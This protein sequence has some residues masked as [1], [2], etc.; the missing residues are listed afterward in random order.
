[1][2]FCSGCGTQ[3]ADGS[4]LCPACSAKAGASAPAAGG[5]MS[6]NVAGMLA[7]VTIIPAIVFLVVA[8]YNKS[9]FVRFHAFQNIFFCI[10][11][12]VLW[13]ALSFVGMIPVLGWA[14]LLIW[15]LLGLGGL[16]LWIIL[17]LKANQGQMWKLP[18]IGDL[19]EKQAS[20][21]A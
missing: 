12:I 16:I 7:Y 14:T 13:V 10:A 9:R 15:P 19:A 11:W 17:L 6:D 21:M 2:A 18:V 1:M 5:G 20:A 4:T 3:I 8:P